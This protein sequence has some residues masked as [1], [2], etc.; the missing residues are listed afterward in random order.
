MKKMKTIASSFPR[1]MDG[2]ISIGQTFKTSTMRVAR[3]PNCA[4]AGPDSARYGMKMAEARL[5]AIPE[6]R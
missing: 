5:P 3:T 4:P 2:E 1:A 6:T